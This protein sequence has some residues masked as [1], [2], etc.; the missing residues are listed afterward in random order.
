MVPCSFPSG[1]ILEKRETKI[2]PIKETSS[3]NPSFET[4]PNQKRTSGSV[5]LI[6]TESE[7]ETSALPAHSMYIHNVL[8]R[9]VPTTTYLVFTNNIKRFL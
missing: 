2:I 3:T 1:S 6:K 7:S 8:T 9:K 5:P 4:R